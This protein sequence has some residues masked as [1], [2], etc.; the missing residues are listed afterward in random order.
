MRKSLNCAHH[1]IAIAILL[2]LVVSCSTTA[3]NEDPVYSV[4]IIGLEQ[5]IS[6]TKHGNIRADVDCDTFLGDSGFDFGDIVEISFLDQN[7][8]V[9]IVPS[10]ASVPAGQAGLALR[11]YED[12]DDPNDLLATFFIN[13]GDFTTTYGIATKETK[14]D[15]SWVW[16]A[17]EGVVFPLSIEIKLVEKGGYLSNL[18]LADLNKTNER[19]DYPELDDRQ[20]ANFRKITTTGM[21]DCLYRSSSP[22]NDELGR[23]TYAMKAI[24]EVGVTVIVNVEEEESKAQSR[25]AY[26]NSYYSAQ[27]VNYVLMTT[28]FMGNANNDAICESMRFMAKNPG[29]YLV[30]CKEGKD[31]TGFVCAILELLMGA[32]MDEVLDDYMIT[33]QN[34]FKVE[35]GTDQYKYISNILKDEL[36]ASGINDESK[37]LEQTEAYLQKIGLNSDEISALKNNLSV[38]I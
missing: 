10:Y 7:L 6:T 31:R 38:R 2:V 3:V 33:F 18:A 24:E 27:N 25:P 11:K 15:K 14:E 23:N 34:Y 13:S 37:L 35:K 32:G 29:I 30:H 12:T 16:H 20:F 8:E 21:G 17:C 1:L 4:K 26:A 28:N 36:S 19:S 9:P 22:I 5:N